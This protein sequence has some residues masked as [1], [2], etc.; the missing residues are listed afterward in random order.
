MNT[1]MP[2]TNDFVVESLNPSTGDPM[3]Y[4]VFESLF[5]AVEFAESH[6][7]HYEVYKDEQ[8]VDFDTI[9]KMKAYIKEEYIKKVYSYTMV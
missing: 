3:H 9:S 8:I 2:Q 4:Y 7:Y 1:H 5:S 6:L